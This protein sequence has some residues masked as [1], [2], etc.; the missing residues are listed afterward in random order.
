MIEEMDRGDQIEN[1]PDVQRILD[2]DPLLRGLTQALVDLKMAQQSNAERFPPGHR[3]MVDL[4]NRVEGLQRQIADQEATLRRKAVVLLKDS[5]ARQYDMMKAQTAALEDRRRQIDSEVTVLNANLKTV[6]D[7]L[8]KRRTLEIRVEELDRRLLELRL[9]Q[10]GAR[11]VSVRRY[12]ATPTKPS[13]PRWEVNL[14]LGVVVGLLVGLGLAFLLELMDTSIRNPTDVSRRV[15]LPLLGVVPHVGDLEEEIQDLR[16]AFMTNPN[17][18]F[19]EA[20]RQIRT[21]LQFSAPAAQLRTVLVTSA[22]PGDGR[23]TVSLNLAAATA[24]G[25]R[26]VLVVE[27]NF[28]QPMLR[29]L[30]PQAPAGGLANVLVGQAN[31]KDL[32]R[33]VHPN[34][35]VLCGGP[36]PPN[37]AELLGSD[38][39]RS[40]VVELAA[41][42]DQ[43]VFDGAPCLLVTDAVV[44]ATLMDGVVLV[45]RAASN[46]Y[47]VVQRAR[48]ILS[49]VG[50]RLFGVVLNG[51]RVTAGG[52]LRKNYRT[53]YEYHAQAEAPAP[54]QQLPK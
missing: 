4:N 22:M 52:Y 41:E 2:N 49:R 13:I 38:A 6:M 48:D 16:L 53:F 47:G 45:V 15:D 54:T 24:H 5:Y 29:A 1:H 11:P 3:V 9:Q 33:E 30:F 17:S 26:R 39:M 50:A 31:W 25:G 20:F 18:L 40:L 44:L 12:A 8:G 43:V 23:S 7:Q 42:Y 21:T 10:Q 34:L 28:R 36:L 32:V 51:I 35:F 27:A 14:P 37:P 46:T 19:G